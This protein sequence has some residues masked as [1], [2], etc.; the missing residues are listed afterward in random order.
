MSRALARRSPLRSFPPEKSREKDRVEG[1]ER[2]RQRKTETELKA[3]R[4][5]DRDEMPGAQAG[6]M[7]D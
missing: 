1:G 4:G 6:K 7:P 3:E 5:R 2:Q